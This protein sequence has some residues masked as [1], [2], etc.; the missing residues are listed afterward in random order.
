MIMTK[1]IKE[2][3][4]IATCTLISGGI[5]QATAAEIDNAWELD[6]SYLY[7]GETNDRVMVNKAIAKLTGDISEQD[8]ATIDLILDTMSGS[9]PT[10]AVESKSS[11]VT[12]T[13]ASGASSV[14]STG[15]VPDMASFSDTRLG[16]SLDW[17]HQKNRLKTVN[18]GGSISIEKDYESYGASIN[19]SQDSK[20]RINTYSIG[21]AYQ[22]D[23]I[24]RKTGGTPE[25]LSSVEANSTFSDGE[26]F[27]YDG[28]AGISHVFNKKTIGQL[29]YGITYSDGYHSDPYK[30]ISEVRLVA[31]S[32]DT[33]N[34]FAYAETDRFYESR[35]DTR[36]RHTLYT[37]LAHQYGGNGEVIHA[38]Y[39]YYQD[40][41][42]IS[43]HTLD[44]KHKTPFKDGAYIEPHLRFYTQTAADF[45]MHS[46]LDDGNPLPD[47]ASADYRLDSL[48]D[49]TVGVQYGKPMA[50]GKFRARFE[51]FNQHA[52]EAEHDENTALIFQVSFQKKFD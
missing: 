4:S 42:G 46:I 33:L 23:K 31:D 1:S 3:L 20:D 40:D 28:I 49:I 8:K 2:Q 34:S 47:Y 36:L 48:I 52:D 14:T 24:Y 5:Q 29:N 16:F 32:D 7:Y 21:A 44:L 50:G 35:P 22:F 30:V 43:A 19:Y 12:F 15:A 45:F 10:G 25:P 41:W 11:A 39:R 27:I 26:R 18:Y 9:T 6:T 51:Y 17:A 13:S 37:G 38:S